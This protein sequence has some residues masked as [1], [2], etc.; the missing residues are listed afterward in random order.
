MPS[1]GDLEDIVD[2]QKMLQRSPEEVAHIWEQ[3]RLLCHNMVMPRSS[4]LNLLIWLCRGMR[5][6]LRTGWLLCLIQRTG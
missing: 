2:I 4:A 6:L 3:A 1:S 5:T